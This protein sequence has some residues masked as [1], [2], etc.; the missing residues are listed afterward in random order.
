MAWLRRKGNQRSAFAR[1]H[2]L[3]YVTHP[4]FPPPPSRCFTPPAPHCRLLAPPTPRCKS[5]CLP[6]PGPIP[7]AGSLRTALLAVTSRRRRRCHIPAP[8]ARARLLRCTCRHLLS[9][10][11]ALA[12]HALACRRSSRFAP[13]LLCR[14][15]SCASQARVSC[16][17]RCLYA[18]RL[19]L[20]PAPTPRRPLLRLTNPVVSIF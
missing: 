5:S 20:L 13:R 14:S 12:A 4:R 3:P 2:P 17:S 1:G 16:S 19:L 10:L 9:L 8:A 11:H 6:V 18:R 7:R 15:A